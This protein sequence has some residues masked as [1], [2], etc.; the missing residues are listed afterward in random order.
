MRRHLRR[1]VQRAF[2]IR[3][4]PLPLSVTSTPRAMSPQRRPLGGGV[5]ESTVAMIPATLRV[6]SRRS[7]DTSKGS[8]TWRSALETHA[9]SPTVACS[10]KFR[11]E[12][13]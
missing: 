7:K 1:M 13:A 10:L 2:H 6:S 4:N 11:S 3:S 8:P 5:C 9:T 12:A